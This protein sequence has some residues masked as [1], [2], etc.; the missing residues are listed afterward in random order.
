MKKIVY[1]R[2]KAVEYAKEWALKRNERYYA[3]DNIGGDCT[4]FVSQCLYAGCKVMNYTKNTG[5]YY[6]SIKDRAPAWTGVQFFYDFLINNKGKGPSAKE[7]LPSEIE[8]GDFIQLGRANGQ[9]YHAVIITKI[10]NGRFY[11]CSHTRDAL[12]VPLSS[13]YYSQI[14]Y[15]HI[16]GA[17]K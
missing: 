3:F 9:F 16:L 17:R 13:Y 10:T 14:R 11:V 15:L 12:N 5:W 2:E 8:V 1:Q 7:V 6:N 4:N